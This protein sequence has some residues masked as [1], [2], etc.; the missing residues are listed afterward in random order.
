[1]PKRYPAEF[2]QRVIALWEA[3][4]KV[5]DIAA[6]LDVSANT[7][8]IWRRQH[9]IDTGQIPGTSSIESAE[10]KKELQKLMNAYGAGEMSSQ[11]YKARKEAL[12]KSTSSSQLGQ[13]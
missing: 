2:R 6:D 10:L 7:I 9:L 8:Y 1:M 4:R 3:G 12:L 11:E 13:Q 5:A